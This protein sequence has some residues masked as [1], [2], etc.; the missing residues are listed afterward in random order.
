[1][2]VYE[3]QAISPTNRIYRDSNIRRSRSKCM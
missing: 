2:Q 3:I 1:M